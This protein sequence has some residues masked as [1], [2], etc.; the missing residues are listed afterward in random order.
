MDVPRGTYR[1]RMFDVVL[2]RTA[3]PTLRRLLSADARQ[4][5]AEHP[6]TREDLSETMGQNSVTP[7]QS[8]LGRRE[9]LRFSRR[10]VSFRR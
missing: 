4:V 3:E 2:G 8:P 10:T 6:V 5:R 7:P 1:D 9:R